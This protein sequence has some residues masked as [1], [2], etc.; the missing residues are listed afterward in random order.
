M[1]KLLLSHACTIKYKMQHRNETFCNSKGTLSYIL[2]AETN[3]CYF[4]IG[5][6]MTKNQL[7]VIGIF[8][9]FIVCR[10]MIPYRFY[11]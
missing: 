11:T 1:L 3:Y 10:A 4:T 9:R 2:F 5:V 7:F 6:P 8:R